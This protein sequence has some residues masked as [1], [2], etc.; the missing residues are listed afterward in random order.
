M[1]NKGFDIINY[2]DDFLG[3][4]TPSVALKSFQTLY[5]LMQKSYHQ[6]EKIGRTH[7]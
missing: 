5:D 1:K 3:F 4:S 7:Y 6:P 2:I